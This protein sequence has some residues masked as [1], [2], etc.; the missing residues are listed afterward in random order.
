MITLSLMIGIGV[1]VWWL[2]RRE[3]PARLIASSRRWA[4]FHQSATAHGLQLLYI[5][6][7]QPNGRSN[8]GTKAFVSVYGN[9]MVAPRDAWFWW[10]DVQQ[11]SVVAVRM[12]EGWGPHTRREDVLFIGTERPQQSGIYDTVDAKTLARARRYHQQAVSRSSNFYY[13][14]GH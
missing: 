5:E 3:E 1:L 13:P 8:R 4:S 14:Q 2:V 10:A 12:S 9:P 7:I 11:G 6:R